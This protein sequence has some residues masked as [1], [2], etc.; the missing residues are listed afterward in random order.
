MIN[1]MNEGLM[2]EIL[3][4]RAVI[5]DLD[6]TLVD[7][8]WMWY[9][10]DVEFL[11]RY[12]LPCPPDLQHMIEGMSFSETADYFKERFSLPESTDEIKE[13]WTDMSLDKYANEVPLRSGAL[14][15]ISFLK[16][17]GIR[18]GI[19][20]SNAA[21]MVEAVLEANGVDRYFDCVMTAR[22]VPRG[23]PAPDIYLRAAEELGAAPEECMVFED[24]P[25][26]IRSGKAAGMMV[27]AV[28]DT[29][30]L[31]YRDEIIS[32]SDYYIRDYSD[33]DLNI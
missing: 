9:D 15:F 7:S 5:F 12:G 11:A 25:A 3:E 16:Q 21:V 23:K 2:Q 8:M 20:T 6:G 13:I 28:E 19:A 30:A 31:P 26:G 29:N 1:R 27:C 10:I 4:K 22:E 24:V 33:L 18:I 14:D 32:L 17:K